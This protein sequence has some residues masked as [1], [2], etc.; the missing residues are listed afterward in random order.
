MSAGC[1]EELLISSLKFVLKTFGHHRLLK[2]GRKE[3][4][5]L[6]YCQGRKRTTAVKGDESYQIQN[7]VNKSVDPAI[8]IENLLLCGSILLSLF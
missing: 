6:E 5:D 4:L 1:A 7:Y 3:P 2:E 8:I